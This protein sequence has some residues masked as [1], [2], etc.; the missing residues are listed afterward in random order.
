[1][2]HLRGRTLARVKDPRRIPEMVDAL[3][4]LWEARPDLTLTQLLSLL[5]THGAGWNATD[6]E[7]LGVLRE[8]TA[9]T[10]AN[11][12]DIPGALTGTGHDSRVAGRYRVGTE[13]STGRADQLITLCADRVAVRRIPGSRSDALHTYPQPV[14]WNHGGV[15]TCAVAHPLVISDSDGAPHH[16]GLVSSITVLATPGEDAGISCLD[17]LTRSTLTATGAVHLL[18][19][20][21]ATVLLDRTLRLF[22]TAR[23]ELHREQ[24]RWTRLLTCS[25]G[26]PLRVA[27]PD[28]GVRELPGLRR[29][30]PLE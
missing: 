10:P 24:L 27:L 23:R 3:T 2:P 1:M 4:R 28:G 30:T 29:I 16:L 8:L 21:D 17:G 14:V 20:D 12:R 13:D 22:T 11:L 9:R 5:E 26:S 15:R 19:L 7:A 6:A 18:E 25:V